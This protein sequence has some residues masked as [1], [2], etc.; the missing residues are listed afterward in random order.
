M[1]RHTSNTGRT[2]MNIEYPATVWEASFPLTSTMP[3]LLN[4][5][6]FSQPKMP[7][8]HLIS[9]TTYSKTLSSSVET[10]PLFLL[11]GKSVV[12]Y[13]HLSVGT[14]LLLNCHLTMPYIHSIKIC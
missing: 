1:I 9:N 4:F 2:T 13:P 5:W 8:S 11:F 6:L 7:I 10:K 3:H 12:R 14:E